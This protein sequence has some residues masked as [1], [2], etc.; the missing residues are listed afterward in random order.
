MRV[1]LI[2]G[3]TKTQIPPPTHGLQPSSGYVPH[4]INPIGVHMFRSF[5]IMVT[6][7]LEAITNFC[8]ALGHI[9]K[10]S[11]E[12]A[13]TFVDEARSDRQKKL[14]AQEREMQALISQA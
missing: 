7:L 2:A 9:S 8:T 11:E 1:G 4:L 13:A 12:T 10:W 3:I 5:N 14:L 6:T